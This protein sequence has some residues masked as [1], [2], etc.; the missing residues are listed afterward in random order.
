MRLMTISSCQNIKEL[1]NK[2]KQQ[3]DNRS[4][5]GKIL[6]YKI[7]TSN[8]PHSIEYYLDMGQEEQRDMYLL[9]DTKT[10]IIT[11]IAAMIVEKY[12]PKMIGNILES[13]YKHYTKEE[14][15]EI[16]GMVISFL[17]KVH[18]KQKATSVILH[19]DVE[20]ALKSYLAE[21]DELILE[22]FIQ[23]RLSTYKKH[24]EQIID[25]IVKEYETQKEYHD[26]IKL[27]QYFVQLQECKLQ[28]VHVIGCADR[29]FKILD[30][31]KNEIT[32]QCIEEFQADIQMLDINYDDLLVSALISIAPQEIVIHCYEEI[33][34]KQLIETIC[35]VF[36]GR[37]KFCQTCEICSPTPVLNLTSK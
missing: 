23:F 10:R 16:Y 28:I 18:E 32:Q 34:N 20:N 37:V 13:K 36:Q 4:P 35:S 11:G 30:E 17:D 12:D 9:E 29:T 26:F 31:Y 15:N 6:R 22:G 25:R 24:L 5:R 8:H 19:K 27:L 21:Q 3:F 1:R 7:N 2:I 33:H 14:R